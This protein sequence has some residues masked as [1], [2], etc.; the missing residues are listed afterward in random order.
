MSKTSDDEDA[1][2]FICK[3][4][5]EKVT[6]FKPETFEKCKVSLMIRKACNLKDKDKKLPEE[7]DKCTGYH[8]ACYR[9]F[10]AIGKKHKERYEKLQEVSESERAKRHK[11][12]RLLKKTSIMLRQI[13]KQRTRFNR[14]RAALMTKEVSVILTLCKYNIYYS[15]LKYKY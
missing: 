3:S 12:P 7:I 8:V 6:L 13:Q 15:P 10:N 14:C 9:S 5:S 4:S 2:C 11:L 1:V